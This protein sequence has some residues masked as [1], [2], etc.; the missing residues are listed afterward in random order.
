[1]LI[2]SR[3]FAI[4]L[5][6]LVITKTYYDYKKRLDSLSTLL[7][8]SIAWIAIVYV[9]IMPGFF[10]KFVQKMSNENVGIGTF[11]GVAFVF[12]FF[13]TYRVYTKA[14]RIE[15]QIHDM[16]MRLGLKDI[17]NLDKK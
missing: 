12:L 2:F 3:I 17:T 8:W 11:V 10:Y 7:F 9:A 6:L 16:V 15:R 5:A 4:F 14:N 13:V 1:M